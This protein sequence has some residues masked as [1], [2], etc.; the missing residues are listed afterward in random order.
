VQLQAVRHISSGL[1]DVVK[2]WL[3]QVVVQSPGAWSA[4]VAPECS[5]CIFILVSSSS[6]SHDRY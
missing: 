6:C 4:D 1:E 2:Y 5:S 3:Q